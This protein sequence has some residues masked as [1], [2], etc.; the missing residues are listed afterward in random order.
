MTQLPP[1]AVKMADATPQERKSVPLTA[2]RRE[3]AAVERHR[4]QSGDTLAAIAIQYYGGERYTQF[5]ID[6]NKQLANPNRLKIGD[7]INIPPAPKR[8]TN[9]ERTTTRRSTTGGGAP[10]QAT[11]R[12]TYTVRS[13]D[14]FYVISRDQ[15]GDAGRW[16]ELFELNRQL[17][18][19]EPT[20][21]QVGQ[22][23]VLPN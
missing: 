4:V 17:V 11:G 18:G 20:A 9:S 6:A 2:E 1:V 5:L 14:S 7:V 15:L 16:K 13:G 22:V 21:L 10:A 23:L 3:S 8:T 19:G 12:R